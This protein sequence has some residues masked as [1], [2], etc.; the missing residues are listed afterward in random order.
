MI[1]VLS[2]LPGSGKTT[3]A[4]GL[5]ER[6]AERGRTVALLHSDDF[7]R[8]TYDRLYESVADGVAGESAAPDLW[9]LDGTFAR[10]EWRNRFYRL[11][12]VREVWV[13]APLTTCLA[14]NRR[15]ADPIPDRGVESVAAEFEPPRADL[16]IDTDELGADESLDRLEAAVNAWL[17][18]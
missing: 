18:E 15:R 2:G 11:D 17:T 16:V 10:R 12:D 7:E 3:L 1:V 8:R 9:L 5:R 6:L 4:T 14:R 13:R